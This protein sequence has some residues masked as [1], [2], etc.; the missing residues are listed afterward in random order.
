[1][2]GFNQEQLFLQIVPLVQFDKPTSV[3]DII[4]TNFLIPK[5]WKISNKEINFHILLFA[6]LRFGFWVS[7]NKIVRIW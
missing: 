6:Y 4:E 1:M 5:I 3:L 2:L 7:Y